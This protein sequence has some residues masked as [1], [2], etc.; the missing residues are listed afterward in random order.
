MWLYVMNN[1]NAYFTLYQSFVLWPGSTNVEYVNTNNYHI[2]TSYQSFV[3]TPGIMNMHSREKYF[4]YANDHI[5]AMLSCA[6]GI[7]L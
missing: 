2:S 3:L 4:I 1:N 7:T 5:S 6:Q